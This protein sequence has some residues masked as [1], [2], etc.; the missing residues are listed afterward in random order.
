MNMKLKNKIIIL[1]LNLISCHIL[2]ANEN[3]S[4]A[5]F[6]IAS[7]Y[8]RQGSGESYSPAVRYTPFIKLSDSNWQAGLSLGA[9]QILLDDKTK[10]IEVEGL[11]NVRKELDKSLA[12]QVSAGSKAWDCRS[13][14]KSSFTVGASVYH[15]LNIESLKYFK[16]VWIQYLYIDQ[17][18]TAHQYLVG[19]SFDFSK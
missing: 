14:R 4:L 16:D 15:S 12:I 6:Q 10:F 5:H 1:I 19:L 9:S 17:K 3:L 11:L 18:K 7:S 13:C 8:L 2:Y